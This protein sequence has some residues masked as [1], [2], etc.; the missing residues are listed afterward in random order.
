MGFLSDIFGWLKRF[1]TRI[2]AQVVDFVKKYWWLVVIVALIFFAPS[3]AVWLS[4]TG[5]PLWLVNAFTF[6]ATYATPIL[7]S[8]WAGTL[9]YAGAAATAFSTASLAVKG[10]LVL[11]AIALV[12]E[13]AAGELITVGAELVSSTIGLVTAGVT[14][15]VVSGIFSASPLVPIALIGAATYF[16]YFRKKEDVTITTDG[17]QIATPIEANADEV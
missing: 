12:D 2:V 14:T 3:I 11:G 6:T 10:A 1:I 13:Q 9:A 17:G 15:G 5:A 7:A 8:V 16:L 4:N